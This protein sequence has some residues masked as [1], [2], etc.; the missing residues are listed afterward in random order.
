MALINKI[1]KPNH[2]P[3]I[4]AREN[5]LKSERNSEIK[6]K[7][8]NFSKSLG[9]ACPLY[10]IINE[11][12]TGMPAAGGSIVRIPYLFLLKTTDIPK[13]FQ[14]SGLDDPLLKSDKFLQ[15]FAEWSQ[16][17]MSVPKKT[18]LS[19]LEKEVIRTFLEFI[20]DPVLSEKAKT[21]VL[22]HEVSHIALKHCHNSTNPIG[23]ICSSLF[24]KFTLLIPVL[25]LAVSITAC[26]TL[27]LPVSL[28]ISL[29][30]AAYLSVVAVQIFRNIRCS[31]ALEKQADLN[32]VKFSQDAKEGG[33]YLF[34]VFRRSQQKARKNSFL[35]RLMYSSSGNNRLLYLTH[36]SE[37]ARIRYLNKA[38]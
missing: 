34:D 17:Y 7:V 19:F 24:S 26:L 6:Q 10:I 3:V 8:N 16:E 32:A 21:F 18:K 36:P 22:N 29:A 13:K 1:S 23:L 14:L 20:R 4:T 15:E 31:R 12:L 5:L 28:V 30:L 11:S 9:N 37:N 27:S 2:S 33:T 25:I 35:A 38:R